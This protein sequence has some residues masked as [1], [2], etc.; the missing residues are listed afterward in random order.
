MKMMAKIK[1]SAAGGDDDMMMVMMMETTIT[2]PDDDL[3][4]NDGGYNASPACRSTNSQC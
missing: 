1:L 4:S 2:R 3:D